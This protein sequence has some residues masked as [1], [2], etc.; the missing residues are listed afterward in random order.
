VPAVPDG[1]LPNADVARLLREIGDLLELD[2]ANP[3]RVRAYRNAA[4][5]ID[6][7]AEPIAVVDARPDTVLENLPGIG[8]DLARTIRQLTFEGGVPLLSKLRK[9][10]PAEE[11]ELLQVRGLGPK[12]I[13]AL[14][15]A[16]GVRSVAELRRA[17]EENRV[18]A[19]PGFGPRSEA[20]LR[21]ELAARPIGA[22]RMPR[23][24]ASQYAAHLIEHMKGVRAVHHVEMAGSFRRC[25]ETVGDLDL[26]VAT[27]DPG[28]AVE[29]FTTAPGARQVLQR[30][31]A[32]ASIR[33]ASGLQ[34]DMRVVPEESFGAALYY[35]TGSK[36]HNIAVRRMA[37][38]RGLKINEYGVFK[39]EERIGGR[40]EREVAKSVGLPWIPPELREDRGE[41]E[42]A[43]KGKLPDL[44]EL[45]DLRGDLQMHTTSSDGRDD[46]AT[47]V[48]A[49][50]NK[51][52]EYIAITDHSPA[53]R[54][55]RG[56]NAAGFRKQGAAI[57]GLNE[58]ARRL[59]VLKSVEVDIRADGSLDLDDR[60]LAGFDLVTASIHSAFDLPAEQQTSRILRA[61]E[62]PSVH[63]LAHPT[64]RLIGERAG[65]SADWDRVFR[66]A[67]E[68]GVWLEVNAQP[69]RLDLD[70]AACRHA[71]SL[72]AILTI[73]SD[74]HS[75]AELDLLRWGVD[76]ARRG[77]VT[78]NSVANTW[79]LTT[80]LRRRKA[81]AA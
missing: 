14:E 76:Q 37:L 13:Q 21:A 45:G 44:V 6:T 23:A 60:A 57:D 5:T 55:T 81:G 53:V 48:G 78:K 17:L 9:H 27:T 32:G 79:P 38:E 24:I 64:S 71:V 12:R 54:V 20:K 25:R 1:P 30:G 2:Q 15:A 7:L 69:S 59:R 26:L 74:A 72:G 58:S 62:H 28:R 70:D 22:P 8:E 11:L 46:L 50:A 39:G 29:A 47:M 68:L 77:W 4:R 75:V 42:A 73:S 43:R 40:T 36:A 67:A 56:M 3:F 35:F 51:G 61:L 49:A 66:S 65:I 33:L 19:V 16:L 41:I 52:H 31:E 18:R 10:I 80:L 34:V 63:I